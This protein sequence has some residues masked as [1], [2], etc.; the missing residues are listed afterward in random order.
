MRSDFGRLRWVA[1]RLGCSVAVGG[2]VAEVR[3]GNGLRGAGA[4]GG[5]ATRPWVGVH[6]AAMEELRTHMLTVN[7]MLGRV[8][9]V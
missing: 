6:A 8:T 1:V 4:H 9:S 5:Q 2:R 3:P 7:M